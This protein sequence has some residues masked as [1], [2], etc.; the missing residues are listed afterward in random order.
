VALAADQFLLPNWAAC[1]EPVFAAE[2]RSLQR[3]SFCCRIAQPAANQFSL[4]KCPAYSESVFTVDFYNQP[5][6]HK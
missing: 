5:P 6:E 2:L 1:S 4:V 3:T